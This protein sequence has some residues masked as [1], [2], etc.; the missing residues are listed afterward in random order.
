MTSGDFMRSL[1]LGLVAAGLLAGFAQAQVQ[2]KPG[3]AGAQPIAPPVIA[4]GAGKPVQLPQGVQIR[5]PVLSPAQIDMDA[6]RK[7]ATARAWGLTGAANASLQPSFW[8][9]P[10]QPSLPSGAL[11]RIATDSASGAPSFASTPDLPFGAIPVTGTSNGAWWVGLQDIPATPR[12]WFLIECIVVGANQYMLNATYP[13]APRSDRGGSLQR[14]VDPKENKVSALFEPSAQ[15]KRQF[16][17]HGL[18]SSGVW[19]FGGCEV[20]PIRP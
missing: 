10:Q 15:A 6:A 4:P 1:F 3:A 18:M 19:R 20:T 8:L 11:L 5:P 16:T 7:V 9:T 12:D 2:I 17:V 14:F 13:G